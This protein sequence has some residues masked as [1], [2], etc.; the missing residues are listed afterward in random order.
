[1]AEL[2]L[3]VKNRAFEVL[4]CGQSHAMTVMGGRELCILGMD[5]ANREETIQDTL[6][7]QTK[8]CQ[9]ESDMNFM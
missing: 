5:E 8:G 9:W 7:Q 4:C 1:M 2:L 3:T 6:T